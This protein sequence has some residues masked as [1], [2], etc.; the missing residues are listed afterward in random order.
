[1][2]FWVVRYS[3]GV[4]GVYRGYVFL[5]IGDFRIEDIKEVVFY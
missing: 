1:M 3:L 5:L 4:I 2:F